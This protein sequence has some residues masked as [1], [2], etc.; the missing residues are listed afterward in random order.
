MFG[1]VDQVDPLRHLIGTASGWGGNPE[2]DATYVTVTPAH[3]DG[4]TVHRLTVRDVP[5][6]GFWSISVYNA[7]GYF[8][9]ND[10]DAYSLNNY[11]ATPNDDGSITV[12]F[13]GCDDTT[14][15]CLPV[16]EGWNYWVR[17]YQPRTEILDGTWTFPEAE[18]VT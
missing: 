3:N 15:N 7:A 14:L 12:Q 10:R 11:T 8:E 1:T 16:G 5:V 17:L 6:D 18:P 2:K 9:P 13:G 4:T